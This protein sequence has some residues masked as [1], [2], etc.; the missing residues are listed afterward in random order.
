MSRE[1][2]KKANNLCHNKNSHQKDQTLDLQGF[3][4]DWEGVNA[5]KLSK[6]SHIDV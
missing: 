5:L 6:M 1:K 3:V 2:C 4:T